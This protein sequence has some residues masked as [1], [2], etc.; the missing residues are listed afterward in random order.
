MSWIISIAVIA[1]GCLMIIKTN[2]FYDFTGPVDWAERHLG[3]EG[4][5]RMLIK[6]IGVLMI[7]GT[8]LAITGIL[9]NIILAIFG[10]S[11]QLE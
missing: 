7:A 11:L 2:W 10:Q 9:Q 4:G 1:V 3:S 6:L 8:F 5:T